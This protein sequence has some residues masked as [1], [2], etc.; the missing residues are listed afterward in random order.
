MTDDSQEDEIPS[1][2]MYR[3]HGRTAGWIAL[4][5]T[6]ILL[7]LLAFLKVHPLIIALVSLLA[8]GL[9]LGFVWSALVDPK[10]FLNSLFQNIQ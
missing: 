8:F 4:S 5:S 9:V 3:R 2:E 1:N 6:A 10:G 7:A